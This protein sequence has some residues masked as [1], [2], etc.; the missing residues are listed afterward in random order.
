ML[1]EKEY[2]K[3]RMARLTKAFCTKNHVFILFKN[4]FPKPDR[5]TQNIV[6]ADIFACINY[7]EFAKI[8]NFAW[9]FFFAFLI[10]LPLYCIIK[11]IFT[12]YIISRIFGK[13]E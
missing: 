3:S 9:I 10:S 8:V 7:G 12:V 4:K 1:P 5:E 13:R 11:V 6:N 2:P